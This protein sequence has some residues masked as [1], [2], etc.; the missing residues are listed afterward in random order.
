[1]PLIQEVF[2]AELA[3]AVLSI[4]SCLPAMNTSRGPS[5]S[6]RHVQSYISRLGGRAVLYSQGGKAAATWDTVWSVSGEISPLISSGIDSGKWWVNVTTHYC[7]S[8]IFSLFF[9]LCLSVAVCLSIKCVWWFVLLNILRANGI[10]QKWQMSI[11]YSMEPII[12]QWGFK[13]GGNDMNHLVRKEVSGCKKHLGNDE[14]KCSNQ[15]QTRTRLFASFFRFAE[16][17]ICHSLLR[18]WNILNS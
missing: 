13:V 11:S 9:S 2:W 6:L 12:A 4:Q 14:W 7:L 16:L 5:K 3:A 15:R 17:C 18:F 10:I 8:D 1:M